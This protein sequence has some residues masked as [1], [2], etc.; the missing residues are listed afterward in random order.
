[1]K[2]ILTTMTAL[3][4]IV[5][6][7]CFTACK[8]AVKPAVPETKTD[9]SVVTLSD[10]HP[11]EE[12]KEEA[13]E[14]DQEPTEDEVA[15]Q[16]NEKAPPSSKVSKPAVQSKPE[17][18]NSPSQQESQG[19]DVGQE[20]SADEELSFATIAEMENFFKKGISKTENETAA[21]NVLNK[22]NGS[23]YRPIT[24]SGWQLKKIV[25]SGVP[26]YYYYDFD[27]IPNNGVFGC[28]LIVFA[29][30]T[31]NKTDPNYVSFAFLKGKEGSKTIV[32]NGNEYVYCLNNDGSYGI[33]WN[34]DGTYF[35]AT[36]ASHTDQIEEILPLLKIEQVS[37]QTNSDHVTQ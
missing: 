8:Q 26:S 6:V 3:C 11:K 5:A 16:E 30:G 27:D 4:I 25:I 17:T 32:I 18:T 35:G 37:L 28:D 34:Q 22:Q 29:N 2:K 10:Q 12:V 9:V 7:F 14:A 24:A 20:E 19:D 15:D 33:A 36:L 21:L 1:M 23:Y 13:N 31:Q